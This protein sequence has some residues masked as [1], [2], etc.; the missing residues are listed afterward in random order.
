MSYLR[1]LCLFALSLPVRHEPSYKQL[2]VKTK[3]SNTN[4]VSKTWTLL[5]T[6]GGKDKA[7]N[8]CMRNSCFTYVIC[9][10]SLCLYLQLFAGGPM[11]YL[12]Y[13]CLLTYSG[14]QHI[15]L[16]LCFVCPRLVFQCGIRNGHHNMEL[17]T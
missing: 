15:I 17:R 10:C 14:D 4:N 9:V 11:F 6:T 3:R 5:Q 1:Y 13:L 16:C 8:V 12:R 2:E 7:N